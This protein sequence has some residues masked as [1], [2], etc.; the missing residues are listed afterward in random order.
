[1]YAAISLCP[2]SS[3]QPFLKYF[4]RNIGL[5]IW[6]KTVIV[7]NY[8]L[9]YLFLSNAFFVCPFSFLYT[10]YFYNFFICSRVPLSYLSIN[11]V[12][13]DCLPLWMATECGIFVKLFTLFEFFQIWIVLIIYNLS[14]WI[15][16]YPSPLSLFQEAY[17]LLL[18]FFLSPPKILFWQ[19]VP[20][21]QASYYYFVVTFRNVLFSLHTLIF[22][23]FI[24][25]V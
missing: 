10:F 16:D 8:V 22:F 23:F 7:S 3:F 18:R 17:I 5:F 19:I 6:L 2:F 1:M 25:I 9:K 21:H 11:L 24:M 15:S 4:S 20:V 12:F 14:M 13:Y